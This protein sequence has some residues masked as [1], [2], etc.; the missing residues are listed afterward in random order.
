MPK[1]SLLKCSTSTRT[2]GHR[3]IDSGMRAG[4]RI[5]C[6]FFLAPISLRALSSSR[7]L[8]NHSPD[9][10]PSFFFFFGHSY[11]L[12][13]PGSCAVAAQVDQRC[14]PGAHAVE[15]RSVPDSA[16]GLQREEEVEVC[17]QHCESRQHHAIRAWDAESHPQWEFAR[18]HTHRGVATTH[19]S[20]RRQRAGIRR[21]TSR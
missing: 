4:A 12:Y 17:R 9:F 16:Q 21:L 10:F 14:S 6:L 15:P 1:T 3:C 2:R 18:P 20:H 13:F 11:V 7:L 5:N 19:C 8:F